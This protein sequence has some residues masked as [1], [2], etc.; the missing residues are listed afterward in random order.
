MSSTISVITITRN[1]G[2]AFIKTAESIL[3]QRFER[4]EWIVVDGGND[5]FSQSIIDIYS[6]R[7]DFLLRESD[8]GI[9]DAWNKGISISSGSHI[10]LLNSGD[11]YSFDFIESCNH[12]LQK[13]NTSILCF[14]AS[15]YKLSGDFVRLFRPRVRLLNYGMY[16]P[17]CWMCI[18]R[19]IYDSLGLYDNVRYSMDYLFVKRV[20]S[21]YS[22]SIFHPKLTSK[23]FGNYVLGGL[24]DKHVYKGIIA[25]LRFNVRFASRYDLSPFFF[26]IFIMIRIF[27]SKI[28]RWC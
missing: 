23:S 14:S 21:T 26:F 28:F 11:S 6:D 7:I 20:I 22:I 24:S 4:F 1:E 17:H 19:Y 18:P 8:S 10:L 16:A 3:H 5:P 15:V 27:V 2:D 12:F 9:A 13:D 25:N